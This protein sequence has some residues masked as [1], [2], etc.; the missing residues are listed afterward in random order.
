MESSAAFNESRKRKLAAFRPAAAAAR[1]SSNRG[2]SRLNAYCC[3][4][5]TVGVDLTCCCKLCLGS[6]PCRSRRR[7]SLY[8]FCQHQLSLRYVVLT[9][10]CSSSSRMPQSSQ[11]QPDAMRVVSR[12]YSVPFIDTAMKSLTGKCRHAS[13]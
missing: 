3:D 5:L 10:S 8:V 1:S 7:S 6:V 12:L 13:T 2:S 9:C 11:L 4:R